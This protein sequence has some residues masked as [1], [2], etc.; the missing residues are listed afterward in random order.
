MC[1][2]DLFPSHDI[3][4]LLLGFFVFVGVFPYMVNV[5]YILGVRPYGFLDIT[6]IALTITSI[7]LTIGIFYYRIF[8]IT[9]MALDTLFNT[10]EDAIFV[11]NTDGR[12]LNMNASA[13]VLLHQMEGDNEE[14]R[15]N[16]CKKLLYSRN[17]EYQFKDKIY[18]I[19]RTPIAIARTDELGSLLVLQR[20]IVTGKQIGRAHV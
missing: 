3:V 4:S 1:S 20:H 14:D 7:L 6:P 12:M 5:L 18:T 13:H 15:K 17:E 11:F 8:K 2:S 16:N 9:P 19:T 10:M